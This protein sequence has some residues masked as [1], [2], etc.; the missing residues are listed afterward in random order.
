[1]LYVASV[2][3]TPGNLKRT[4]AASLMDITIKW[5]D[6]SS[7]QIYDLL[8]SRHWPAGTNN[9]PAPEDLLLGEDG[10]TDASA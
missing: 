6:N 2:P 8:F 4:V 1:M 5:Y 7:D 10:D 9:E 3:A